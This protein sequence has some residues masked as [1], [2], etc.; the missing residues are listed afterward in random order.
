M[1]YKAEIVNQRGLSIVDKP[2]AKV[3]KC[4]NAV[5]NVNRNVNQ[6]QILRL[7]PIVKRHKVLNPLSTLSTIFYIKEYNSKN[8][9]YT[10]TYHAYFTRAREDIAYKSFRKVRLTVD[11]VKKQK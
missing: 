5:N 2:L 3:D 9:V 1:K 10:Y 4:R 7:T 6:K 8:V 11:K